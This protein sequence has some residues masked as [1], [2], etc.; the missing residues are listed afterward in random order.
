[1]GEV[2]A[3]RGGPLRIM[4]AASRCGSLSIEGTDPETFTETFKLERDFVWGPEP[5]VNPYDCSVSH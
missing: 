5:E 3:I 1:L 2:A 4:R